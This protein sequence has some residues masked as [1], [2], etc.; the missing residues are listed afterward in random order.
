LPKTETSV[1]TLHHANGYSAL[2][3]VELGFWQMEFSYL[4]FYTLESSSLFLL[5]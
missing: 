5:A 2:D 1:G 4:G 3:D